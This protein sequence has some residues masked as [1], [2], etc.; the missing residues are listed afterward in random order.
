[1][2]LHS[3]F[4]ANVEK[5]RRYRRLSQN[6]LADAAGLTRGGLSTV[7]ND[8]GNPTLRTVEKLANALEV[9]AWLLLK[10]SLPTATNEP[11]R[12]AKPGSTAQTPPPRRGR[13]LTQGSSSPDDKGPDT[14]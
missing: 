5:L 9:E 11:A 4:A 7:L 6:H 10:P 8:D 1:M 13:G 14:R 12:P 3:V 2:D